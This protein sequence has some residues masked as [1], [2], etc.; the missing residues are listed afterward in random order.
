M[1]CSSFNKKY[2]ILP[3]QI[4]AIAMVV[5]NTLLNLNRCPTGSGDRFFIASHDNIFMIAPIAISGA[6]I[7]PTPDKISFVTVGKVY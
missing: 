7:I 6:K 1:R 4:S 3:Y 2:F 5:G